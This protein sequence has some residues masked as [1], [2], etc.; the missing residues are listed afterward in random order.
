MEDGFAACGGVHDTAW[1]KQVAPDEFHVQSVQV[2]Q[3]GA[4]SHQ[5]AHRIVPLEQ[6]ADDV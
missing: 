3:V 6:A 2:A 5:R 4:L 1:L